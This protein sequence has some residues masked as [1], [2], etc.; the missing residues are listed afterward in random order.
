MYA[1][2]TLTST[3]VATISAYNTNNNYGQ[4]CFCTHVIGRMQ[5]MHQLIISA[6]LSR[7]I[8]LTLLIHCTTVWE[9]F[10]LQIM[11]YERFDCQ[12]AASISIF[13][14]PIM[15]TLSSSFSS[16]ASLINGYNAP[17]V[18][19]SITSASILNLSCVFMHLSG[20]YREQ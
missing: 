16:F 4:S 1:N 9:V 17:F 10:H 20:V 13:S 5:Q 11:H 18:S 19:A 6:A 8:C 7:I 14:S 2:N 12:H 15:N 3:G